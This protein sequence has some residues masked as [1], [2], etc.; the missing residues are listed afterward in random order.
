M[1]GPPLPEEVHRLKKIP[2]IQYSQLKELMPDLKFHYTHKGAMW[3]AIDDYNKLFPGKEE[4]SVKVTEITKPQGNTTSIIKSDR[5]ES[6]KK[7]VRWEEGLSDKPSEIKQKY[8][9]QKAQKRKE[10]RDREKKRQEKKEKKEKEIKRKDHSEEVEKRKDPP[11][12]EEMGKKFCAMMGIF[13]FDLE[14]DFTLAGNEETYVDVKLLINIGNFVKGAAIE[15]AQYNRST[16][17]LSIFN[18]GNK[19]IFKLRG[20]IEIEEVFEVDEVI[21]DDDDD[22][23]SDENEIEVTQRSKRAKITKSTVDKE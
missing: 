20:F 1:V 4:E 22:I 18:M 16:G 11:K 10:Q 5:G 2:Q 3:I 13:S 21:K 14:K 23:Q 6:T 15:L 9:L 7:R 12:L 17:E 19:S 8:K